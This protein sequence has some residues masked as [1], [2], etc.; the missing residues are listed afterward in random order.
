MK[1]FFKKINKNSESKKN[2]YQTKSGFTMV[3]LLVSLAIFAIMTALIL[4]KYGKFDQGIILT[5]LAYDVALTIRNAQSYGLNVRSAS[6]DTS[7]FETTS[8]GATSGGSYGVHFNKN[9]KTEFIFFVNESG[10]GVY[11]DVA[12]GFTN[13]DQ[14]TLIKRNSSIL[15]MCVSDA[16]D[17]AEGSPGVVKNLTTLDITFKRP[18][19]NAIIMATGET[20]SNGSAD[21][22]KKYGYAEIVLQALDGTTRK[23]IV[24]FTGQISV[25]SGRVSSP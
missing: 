22:T 18:D 16:K 14:K 19:P 15:S 9:K 8:N 1:L 2:S 13:T 17:C 20:G 3:E 12:G 11:D 4:S 6:R 24:N 5:N 23:V 21:A 10:N 7:S 25:D